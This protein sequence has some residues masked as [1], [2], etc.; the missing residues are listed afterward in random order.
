M[1]GASLF[2]RHATVTES[3]YPFDPSGESQ[4]NGWESSNAFEGFTVMEFLLNLDDK[5]TNTV[6]W[7]DIYDFGI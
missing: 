1:L 2:K 7:M 5:A 4:S 3:S 6:T